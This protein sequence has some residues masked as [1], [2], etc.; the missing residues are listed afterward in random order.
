MKNSGMNCCYLCDICGITV[1]NPEEK[2]SHRNPESLEGF[3]CGECWI[4]MS[5]KDKK[6]NKYT[7]Q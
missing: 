4:E 1:D 6:S 5:K 7:K 2:E 3:V